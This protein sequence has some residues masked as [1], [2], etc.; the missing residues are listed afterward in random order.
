MN[1]LRTRVRVKVGLGTALT[2]LAALAVTGPADAHTGAKFEPAD[3][4]IYTGAGQSIE[5]IVQMTNTGDQNRK[6]MLV[7]AYDF[8]NTSVNPDI[9]KPQADILAAH[10]LYPGAKLQIGMEL[11][12]NNVAE[13][14]SVGTGKYDNW[15]RGMARSYKALDQDIFLRIGYEFDG[16][17]NAYQPTPYVAAYKRIVDLFREQAV[18]NVAFVWNSYTPDQDS[19]DP[20]NPAYR[21]GGNTMMSWYPG[22]TYVDWFSYNE[23]RNGFNATWFNNLAAAQS[24]PVLI[25]EQ[26][27]TKHLDTGYTFEQ[28]VTNHFASVKSSGAKGFQY[29]NWNWPIYPINDWDTWANGKYTATPALVAAY[30][31]EMQDAKYIVRDSTYY[32]PIPLYVAASRNSPAG[33]INSPWLQNRDEFSAQPGYGYSVPSGLQNYG[34]GWGTYWSNPTGTNQQTVNLTVPASSSGYVILAAYSGPLGHDVYAGT[35]KVSTAIKPTAPIKFKYTAADLSGTTLAVKV[36]VPD[37]STIHVDA[38]GVQTLSTA[39]PA[40]P[41][42]LTVSAATPSSVSLT[43]ADVPNA[44]LYNVYRNGQ[45]VGTSKTTSYIDPDLPTYTDPNLPFGRTYQYTVSAWHDH[46]GE[47]D[48][49]AAVTATTRGTLTDNMDSWALTSYHTAGMLLATS[50]PVNFAGDTSRVTRGIKTDEYFTYE[51]DGMKSVSFDLY[52][53]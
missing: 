16:A 4:M 38:I 48:M 40:I 46:A 43:W 42:S 6:P 28:W 17:W 49:S 11:P 51:N 18:T 15:I 35:R 21:Y 34:D 45:L 19:A 12:K 23:W 32:N 52:Y 36:Q 8:L 7:A 30:N 13:L 39:A 31:A 5:S 2:L 26:S 10:N 3:G 41:T 14:E 44:M 50:N 20:L 1:N 9:Y 27:F 25:G 24:K 22:A 29:I 47:G 33:T 37:T 53:T